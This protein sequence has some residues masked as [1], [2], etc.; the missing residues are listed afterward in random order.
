MKKTL[1]TLSLLAVSAVVAAQDSGSFFI[2]V[3]D[4]SHVVFT[5]GNQTVSLS[6]GKN[7]I[8]YK[9]W[10]NL[11]IAPAEGWLIESLV[12]FDTEG[13][14]QSNSYWWFNTS[15]DS[16]ST[17]PT[18]YDRD[19]YTYRVVTKEY[20]PELSTISVNLSD[21]AAVKNGVYTVG[22]LSVTASAGVSDVTFNPEKGDKLTMTLSKSVGEASMTLNGVIQESSINGLGEEIYSFAVAD[23]DKVVLSAKM[24][25]PEFTLRVDNA[26]AVE[27]TFPDADTRLEGLQTGANELTY[28]IGDV[29]TVKAAE[30]FRI[31]SAEGLRY[32]SY[33]NTW[34]YTFKGGEGGMEFVVETEVYN[35]P[36]AILEINLEDPSYVARVVADVVTNKFT[37][38]VNVIKVNLEKDKEAQIVYNIDNAD[39]IAPMLDGSPLAVEYTWIYSSTISDLQPR[40]YSISIGAP[41]WTP[42][43]V[44]TMEIIDGGR[45]DVFSVTG[46]VVMRGADPE[47]LRSLE[48]GLYI[49]NGKKTLITK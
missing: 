44:K 21:P 34:S 15:T 9:T 41:G 49:I 43:G 37:S 33:T 14:Q 25:T 2:E 10:D 28:E 30:G 17:Q 45:A 7:T 35:P 36:M 1:L 32:S 6:A 18:S 46:T 27:V 4:P 12:A 23:G 19:G 8:V 11:T 48:P 5:R 26:N 24:E 22:N 13:I 31:T 20:R 3:D 38:G 39:Q 42:V 40:T 47:Q 16:Y 29:L